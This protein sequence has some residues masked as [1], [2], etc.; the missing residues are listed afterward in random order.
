MILTLTDKDNIVDTDFGNWLIDHIRTKLIS[1]INS[2]K[3][4]TWNEFINNTDVL[5]RL[6]NSS[7]SAEAI[8][9]YA[10]KHLKCNSSNGKIIIGIDDN[11]L[12]PGFDR[13]KLKT[14]CKLINY[15]TTDI[16][17]YPIFSDTFNYFKDNIL[18]YVRMYYVI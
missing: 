15:G 17:G 3:L 4:I 18:D 2:N 5:D 10:S 12:V 8:I 11:I 9:I 13:L 1:S 7:Y 6:Y 16:K 14:I